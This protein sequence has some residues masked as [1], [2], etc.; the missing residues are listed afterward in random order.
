MQK[1]GYITHTHAQTH[2][3]T[4]EDRQMCP[5]RSENKQ[6]VNDTI[7][8]LALVP[9]FTDKVYTRPLTDSE[10]GIRKKT[11]WPRHLRRTKTISKMIMLINEI[12]SHN[13][14]NKQTYNK[15][16]R[17][18]LDCNGSPVEALNKALAPFCKHCRNPAMS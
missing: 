8:C 7:T 3:D 12:F 10:I 2:R 1:T 4:Q 5:K 13:N 14:S 17:T 6:N 11:H 16:Q 18:G 15:V 9:H